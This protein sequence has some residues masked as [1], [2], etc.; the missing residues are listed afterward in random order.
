M[1][2]KWQKSV[3]QVLWIMFTVLLIGAWIHL[4]HSDINVMNNDLSQI[5]SA[6]TFLPCV[7]QYN[8]SPNVNIFCV[9]QDSR[10]IELIRSVHAE[11]EMNFTR[12]IV[13]RF[14]KLF[15]SNFLCSLFNIIMKECWLLHL[16]GCWDLDTF[17]EI[18]F[19]R[20]FVLKCRFTMFSLKYHDAIRYQMCTV[21][22]KAISIK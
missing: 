18:F 9:S 19:S 10:E 8:R 21:W 17:K 12:L 6:H 13:P 2:K 3:A 15:L 16:G 7:T 14:Q 11:D 20:L 5:C 22:N 1:W 4:Q